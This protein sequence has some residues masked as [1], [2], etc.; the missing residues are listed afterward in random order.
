MTGK[1][2]KWFKKVKKTHFTYDSYNKTGREQGGRKRREENGT[3]DDSGIYWLCN[4]SFLEYS[5]KKTTPLWKIVP[6]AINDDRK[7]TT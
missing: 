1:G 7:K 6:F 3:N 2:K 5:S 4:S